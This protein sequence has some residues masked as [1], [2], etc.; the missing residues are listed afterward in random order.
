[1]QREE[2]LEPCFSLTSVYLFL[3]LF[4]LLRPVQTIIRDKCKFLPQN[5]CSFLDVPI[6]IIISRVGSNGQVSV[7][8]PEPSDCCF[9]DGCVD[10]F[11]VVL[12]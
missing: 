4:H 10:L 5:V 9:T 2:N 7:T 1:M 8:R 11:S 12:Y 3:L 6:L